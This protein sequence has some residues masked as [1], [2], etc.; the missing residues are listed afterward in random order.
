[1]LS[2]SCIHGHQ[3]TLL[4]IDGPRP[5]LD[6]AVDLN[7]YGGRKS[8]VCVNRGAK[9]GRMSAQESTTWPLEKGAGK[10]GSD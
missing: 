10:R 2:Q 9:S 4:L 5:R 3:P 7:S 8:K 1:M 6:H